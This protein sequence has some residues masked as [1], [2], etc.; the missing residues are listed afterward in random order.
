[1]SQRRVWRLTSVVKPLL[2]SSKT[3]LPDQ[4]GSRN[5]GRTM[6]KLMLLIA[7]VAWST[8][9]TWTM[10]AGAIVTCTMATGANAQSYPSRPITLMVP[11]A[12]GGPTD[13]LAR[14]LAES[15]RQTL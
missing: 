11:S 3:T 8:A 12:A 9:V 15:M 5:G 1:M 10:I 13:T 4:R 2:L 7:T 14:I 6:K